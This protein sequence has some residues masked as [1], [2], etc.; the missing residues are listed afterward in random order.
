V[1]QNSWPK[2]EIPGFGSGLISQESG[3]GKEFHLNLVLV[4]QENPEY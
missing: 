4:P 3:A 2:L 1:Y